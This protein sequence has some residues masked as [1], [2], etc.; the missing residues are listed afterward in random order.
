M[1]IK[2]I[3]AI[4]AVT[5]SKHLLITESGAQVLLDCG[6]Y[7][8]VGK[9]KEEW[10]RKLD[11]DPSA[12]EAVILSH[13]HIDH[14]GNL[15]SLVKQGFTGSIHCTEATYDVCKI[16][17][18]DSAHIHENDIKYLNRKRERNGLAPLKPLYTIVDAEKCLKHFNP[19]PY[20]TEFHLNKELTFMFTDTGHIIGS[21]AVNIICKENGKVTKLAFSG[22]VGRYTD[23]LLKSP[24]VFP[25][26][27]YIICESTYGDRLHDLEENA[28]A[29]LLAIVNRTCVEKQGKLIIPA[30]S[31]GRTQ[32]IVF[33]L[34][35]MKNERLLPDIKIYVD[36]PLSSSATDIMRKHKECFNEALHTY[37][38]TDPD[39]FGFNNL[40]YIQNAEESKAIN[41]S[42]EPCIIISASG[43]CDAGR[44]KHHIRN[45][46]TDQKNTVL[47]TGYCTPGTLGSR[48]L[49]GEKSVRIFG[50]YYNVNA[51]VESI[52]SYSAH[53]DYNEL[54]KF[55]SCQDKN[56]IKSIFL[57]HGE[58][59]AKAS[60][61]AKLLIEGYP[62]VLIPEKGTVISLE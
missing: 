7:Q 10:N 49:S 5:G 55:L 29:K 16:L 54:L 33:A 26:A 40:I 43:M 27:D 8:G 46:I 17:L 62:K 1:K 14:S 24:D 28:E 48:L 42:M 60:F 13:A 2:F 31:L 6:L 15:P 61:M 52:L 32:E 38:H 34:D 22:D 41:D 12:I 30:F 11:V 45:N 51:A 23:L 37:I 25:Q 59:S 3:G 44:V 56:K 53:A 50:E 57:V 47:I 35:K 58:D 19:I 9:E 4:A 21:A 36:S 20:R 39:P 18:L